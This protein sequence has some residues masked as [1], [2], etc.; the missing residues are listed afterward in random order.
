MDKTIEKLKEYVKN[1]D[2]GKLRELGNLALEK[3]II[4]EN[5][6]FIYLSL[7]SYALSKVF[8]KRHFQPFHEVIKNKVLEII[9]D[10]KDYEIIF[11]E[12]I[13]N[14]KKIDNELG[15]YTVDIIEKAKLKQALRAYALGMTI[16]KA[17]ELTSCDRIELQS[18][19]GYTKIHDKP[20]N[21]SKP[22][23]ERFKTL[24]K[25]FGD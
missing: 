21:I 3:A 4:E 11:K 13:E 6:N 18:Y 10:R 22:V 2:I 14:I 9:D 20:Y 23:L 12:I 7:I 24:K 1:K 15:W 17:C 25:I 8:L 19:I 16:N 5:K